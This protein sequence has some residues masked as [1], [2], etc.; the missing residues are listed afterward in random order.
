MLYSDHTFQNVRQTPSARDFKTYQGAKNS[1]SARLFEL[2][3][4][5]KVSVFKSWTSEASAVLARA[6]AANVVKDRMIVNAFL[7]DRPKTKTGDSCVVEKIRNRSENNI[8]RNLLAVSNRCPFEIVL[9]GTHP[10]FGDHT[11]SALS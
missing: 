1:I 7:Q 2:T 11:H 9:V 10:A 8:Y 3:K 4:S 6:S 5:L